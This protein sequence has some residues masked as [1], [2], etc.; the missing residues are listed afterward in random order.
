M[1]ATVDNFRQTIVWNPQC[2]YLYKGERPYFRPEKFYNVTRADCEW[3]ATTLTQLCDWVGDTQRM[4]TETL[5]LLTYLTSADTS[6]VTALKPSNVAETRKQK[7]RPLLKDELDQPT[8]D[9]VR[10]MTPLDWYLYTQATSKD[11]SFDFPRWYYRI[12]KQ[13]TAN[14]TFNKRNDAFLN[15]LLQRWFFCS[16]HSL[17]TFYATSH[18]LELENAPHSKKTSAQPRLTETSCIRNICA[19]GQAMGLDC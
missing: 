7:N 17:D 12:D 8:I 6:K 4:T 13:S 11:F 10:S 3:V 14:I 16:V 2:L 19:E 15:L 1:K 5:P 9:L 18:R